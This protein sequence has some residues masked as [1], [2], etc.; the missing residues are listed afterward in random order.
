MGK[1]EKITT[2]IENG[3]KGNFGIFL[4]KIFSDILALLLV[5]YLLLLI[6]EGVM[7]GLATAHLS[8][9]RLTLIIFSVLGIV[10]Y[11]GTL[12]NITFKLDNKPLTI[13]QK[14]RGKKAAAIAS[15]VVLSVI[16]TMNSLLKFAWWEIGVI[17]IA[18]IAAI[19]YLYKNSI[20]SL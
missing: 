10:I 13:F 7:P 8:F 12:N 20:G 2:K 11:T 17:T 5:S 3:L 16:L 4:Y 19:F 18:T 14:A 9:T 1:A 6:S 15:I